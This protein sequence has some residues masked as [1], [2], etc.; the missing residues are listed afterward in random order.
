MRGALLARAKC[1]PPPPTS[2]SSTASGAAARTSGGSTSAPATSARATAAKRTA[3]ASSTRTRRR[4][5]RAI[6]ASRGRTSTRTRGRRRWASTR[7]SASAP[8]APAP[9]PPPAVPPAAAAQPARLTTC[10][11]TLHRR[12]RRPEARRVLRAHA[13]QHGAVGDDVARLVAHR[14]LDLDLEALAR[15]PARAGAVGGAP[16]SCPRLG[17]SPR[18]SALRRH[19]LYDV[20]AAAT[21]RARALVV[22]HAR[23]HVLV[24]RRPPRKRRRTGH[25]RRRRESGGVLTQAVRPLPRRPGGGDPRRCRALRR[26]PRAAGRGLRGGALRPRPISIY[27]RAL[28]GTQAR[29]RCACAELL[30]HLGRRRSLIGSE[31][32][33]WPPVSNSRRPGLRTAG[34]EPPRHAACAILCVPD[35]RRA[36]PPRLADPPPALPLVIGDKPTCPSTASSTTQSSPASSR[37]PPSS[38][39]DARRRGAIHPSSRGS[40]MRRALARAAG[41]YGTPTAARYNSTAARAS[42]SSTPPPSAPD[43][44]H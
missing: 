3:C 16:S 23:G 2:P 5:K 19:L 24:T 11:T 15:H 14:P 9:A 25:D 37:A 26:R 43:S 12:R 38:A 29:S 7:G 6:A 13:P 32:I 17:R 28:G 8:S 35:G 30:R 39:T 18:R 44:S 34:V 36:E 40:E 27:F 33:P 42:S 20:L 4:R 31:R 22:Q 21:A 10:A 41:R 1:P